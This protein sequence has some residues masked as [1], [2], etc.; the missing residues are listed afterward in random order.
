MSDHTPQPGA[1]P[2]SLV[3]EGVGRSHGTRTVLHDVCLARG[4]P[5]VVGVAGPN[6]CGKTSLLR[7]VAQLA[8]A[9]SGRVVVC[10]RSI[11][12]A[13]DRAARRL[14]GFAP[15]EPLAWGSLSVRDNLDYAL[16]LCGGLRAHQRRG[17]V[18]L[19]IAEWGLEEVAAQAARTL[20]RGWLQ[21]YSLARADLLHPPVLLLDEPTVSLD[22]AGRL[23]LDDALE[24]WRLTRV[25]VV[26]SHDREWLDAMA[27]EVLELGAAGAAAPGPVARAQVPA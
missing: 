19:A 20:S 1:A 10:G 4:E 12:R 16:R 18:V 2:A 17:R 8:T 25:V 24:R 3:L 11:E 21:R 23:L 9:S 27:D 22:D 6:G 13:D 26:S 15:H 14:V 5:G 7:V